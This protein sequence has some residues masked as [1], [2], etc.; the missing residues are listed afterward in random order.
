MMINEHWVVFMLLF[1][2]Y[3]KLHAAMMQLTTV[4]SG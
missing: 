2:F 3:S 4:S 1:F